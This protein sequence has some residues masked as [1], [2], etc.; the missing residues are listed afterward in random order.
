MEYGQWWDV[1][2]SSR[3][4]EAR[5]VLTALHVCRMNRREIFGSS[6]WRRKLLS[7]DVTG[8]PCCRGYQDWI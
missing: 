1:M 4:P 7:G 5:V 3:W 6:V 8:T 2:G